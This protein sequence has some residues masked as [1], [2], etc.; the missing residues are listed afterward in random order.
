MKAFLFLKEKNMNRMILLLLVFVLVTGACTL[1]QREPTPETETQTV[2]PTLTATPTETS[3]P[4][5]TPTEVP[6]PPETSTPTASPEPFISPT[7]L[8]TGVSD[9]I[10]LASGQP[11]TI[12]QIS[13]FDAANGWGIGDQAHSGDRILITADGGQ[14]W[15][16]R[17]PPV[18]APAPPT[19]VLVAWAYFANPQSAW[20][21]FVP[22]GPPPV[23]APVV[24][25]TQDGGNSWQASTPLPVTGNDAWFQPEGFAFVNE[26]IGWLLVHVG[27]GMSHDYSDLFFTQDGGQNWERIIDPYGNGLQSLHNTGL[28]FADAQFGWVTK[29]N[30]GVMPGAFLEQTRDGGLT[31]ENIFLPAPAEID[32]INEPSQCATSSPVFPE[33]GVGI[34]LVNCQTFDQQQTFSYTYRTS[35]QGNTWQPAQLATPAQSLIF[36][37]AQIAYALGR[38]LYRSTDSGSS[39]IQFK[40]VNWIG[41]FSFV[42]AQTAWAVAHNN[43]QIALVYTIDGGQ[44]WQML[45]PITQ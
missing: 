23:D 18:T 41:Q 32:W 14:T 44:T 21:V 39:W 9:L 45:T 16:E 28:A 22:E 36:I 1:T 19:D 13:M 27:A 5:S 6:A 43:G 4:S 35:D 31:W 3:A 33:P 29:D 30:I 2:V 12:T 8:E 37:D 15:S 26:N 38:E 24:W 42:D 34:V 20:A 40:S 7:P 10:P 25:R 17:T 11:V